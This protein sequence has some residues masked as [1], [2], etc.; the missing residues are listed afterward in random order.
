MPSKLT[1]NNMKTMNKITVCFKADIKTTSK[2]RT[3]YLFR[4]SSYRKYLYKKTLPCPSEL[5]L[6]SMKWKKTN[7][8][9][10]KLA[11]QASEPSPSYSKL[12]KTL[13]GTSLLPSTHA[14][15]NCYSELMKTLSVDPLHAKYIFLILF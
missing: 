4:Q 5:I 7:A 13:S 12:M 9:S 3:R 1:L 2:T 8:F 14:L 15:F 6:E 10:I 11:A